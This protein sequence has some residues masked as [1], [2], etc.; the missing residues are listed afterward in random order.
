MTINAEMVVPLMM[1]CAIKFDHCFNGLFFTA[2]SRMFLNSF[3]FGSVTVLFFSQDHSTP[4]PRTRT[5]FMI[6]GIVG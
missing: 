2:E 1:V 6:Y 3:A 5:L 4:N